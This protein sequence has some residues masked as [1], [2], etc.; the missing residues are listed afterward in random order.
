M[1]T[2]I[3]AIAHAVYAAG[4]TYRTTPAAIPTEQSPEAVASAVVQ[5]LDLA[6]LAVYVEEGTPE[7]PQNLVWS[8][9]RAAMTAKRSES[10]T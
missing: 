3:R 9:V 10:T 5:Q 7:P 1:F 4:F 2:L 6:P 8:A